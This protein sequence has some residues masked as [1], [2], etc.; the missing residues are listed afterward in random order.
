[1]PGPD[2]IKLSTEADQ[3][4]Q[5][6]GGQTGERLFSVIWQ[7]PYVPETN[8]PMLPWQ[9]GGFA[10]RRWDVG[11]YSVLFHAEDRPSGAVNMVDRV[12]TR[13]ALDRAVARYVAERS[14]ELGP[15]NG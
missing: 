1:M 11:N 8:C 7:L 14:I 9:Q 5:A 3:D 6:I 10:V 15:E 2:N 4:L 12:V 13:E